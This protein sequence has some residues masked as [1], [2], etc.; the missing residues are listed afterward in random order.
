MV[1][2]REQI[3]SFNAQ[4]SLRQLQASNPAHSA[5]VSANAGSGKTHVLVATR[6]PPD[7][8][9]RAA[10]LDPLSHLHQG[11][12]EPNMS[13]RVFERLAHWTALDDDRLAA[14]IARGRGPGA[15]TGSS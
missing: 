13:N 1:A 5:W 9:W 11:G 8:R 14:E 7:A 12:G 2:V 6:D 10:V 4:A 3:M 15:T